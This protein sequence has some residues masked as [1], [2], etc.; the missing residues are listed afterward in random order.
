M[1][2]KQKRRLDCIKNTDLF[3]YIRDNKDK[4]EAAVD[5]KPLIKGA[6]KELGFEFTQYAWT[7][8][9]NALDIK[10]R[11]EKMAEAN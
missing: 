9:C 10:N 2:K 1:K 7:S 11:S 5:H 6:E 4:I 3:N 8:R